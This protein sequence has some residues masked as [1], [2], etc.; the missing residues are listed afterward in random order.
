MTWHLACGP[1]TVCFQTATQLAEEVCF[2]VSDSALLPGS[3]PLLWGYKYTPPHPFP[4]THSPS[5]PEKNL[6]YYWGTYHRQWLVP[7]QKS[8]ICERMKIGLTS[9]DAWLK[10]L[11]DMSMLIRT[12]R[13]A[14]L[15]FTLFRA[16]SRL[17]KLADSLLWYKACWEW[18]DTLAKCKAAADWLVHFLAACLLYSTGKLKHSTWTKR[19]YRPS[20]NQPG[21][22]G[23]SAQEKTVYSCCCLAFWCRSKR[24]SRNVWIKIR[25]VAVAVWP[26]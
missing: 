9:V 20:S 15:A 19:S 22:A 6:Y 16:Q 21:S 3:T 5:L 17:S 4:P 24:Q 23:L 2:T 13:T 26:Q 25:A 1:P 18:L 12:W 11:C 14:L 8:N 10:T 7:Y